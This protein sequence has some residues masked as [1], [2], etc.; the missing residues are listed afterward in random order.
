MQPACSK[1][2]DR[3]DDV[4]VVRAFSLALGRPPKPEELQAS[5]DFLARQQQQINSETIGAKNK[6][7]D[8]S[9]KA[10]EAFCLVMLNTNEL[11]YSH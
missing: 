11:V 9:R 2:R 3:A 10:L 4:Q 1:K 7:S 5:L 6:S 8:S